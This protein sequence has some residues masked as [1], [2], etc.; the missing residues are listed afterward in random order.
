MPTTMAR[1]STSRSDGL[2]SVMRDRECA[3]KREGAQRAAPLRPT[4]S[5]SCYGRR[6]PPPPPP[7]ECPPPPPPPPPPPRLPPPPPDEPPPPPPP[8]PRF[9]G[10]REDMPRSPPPPPLRGALMPG[11]PPR[12]PSSRRSDPRASGIE[13]S[14]GRSLRTRIGPPRSRP[15]TELSPSNPPR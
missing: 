14:D 1:P 8:P 7:P 10:G 2:S 9:E 11:S 4:V 5:P 3:L 12:R 6:C 15:S 13:R